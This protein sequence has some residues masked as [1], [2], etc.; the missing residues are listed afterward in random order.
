[1]AEEVKDL[2]VG[3]APEFTGEP[4]AIA[5]RG[6]TAEKIKRDVVRGP[7]PPLLAVTAEEGMAEA[8]GCWKS[9]GMDSPRSPQRD[10]ACP[11]CV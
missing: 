4:Q 5:W 8:C 7:S 6:E 2:E 11:H 1:M 9:P 10:P 3:D